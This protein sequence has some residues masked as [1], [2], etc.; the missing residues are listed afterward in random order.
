VSKIEKLTVWYTFG[1]QK[2][3]DDDSVGSKPSAFFDIMDLYGQAKELGL[4]KRV[5]AQRKLTLTD[6]GLGLHLSTGTQ[7]DEDEP[8]KI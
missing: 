6:Q 4:R 2:I 1:N 3:M 5:S 7:L 8:A